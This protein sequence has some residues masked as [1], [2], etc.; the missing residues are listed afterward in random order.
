[1][2]NSRI[3]GN[4]QLYAVKGVCLKWC[5]KKRMPQRKLKWKDVT[6]VIGMMINSGIRGNEQLWIVKRVCLRWC[7]KKRMPQRKLKWK[8]ATKDIGMVRDNPIKLRGRWVWDFQPST[9][10]IEIRIKERSITKNKLK[11]LGEGSNW[12]NELNEKWYT[13]KVITHRNQQKYQMV[14]KSTKD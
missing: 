3:R 9:P 11:G 8:D 12:D 14:M 1:M 2:I 10:K 5:S 7:F 13:L 6:N 4:E